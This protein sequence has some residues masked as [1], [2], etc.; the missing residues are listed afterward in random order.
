MGDDLPVESVRVGSIH[1]YSPLVFLV[2]ALCYH[3]L[4]VYR[5]EKL[6]K[7]CS[8]LCLLLILAIIRQEVRVVVLH[9][10]CQL[11]Q[12]RNLLLRDAEPVLG[13]VDSDG[14]ERTEPLNNFV[15]RSILSLEVC[16]L[17]H[18]VTN[19]SKSIIF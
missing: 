1:K 17:H 7:N 11:L 10:R 13:E 5:S 9:L 12:L 15:S 2:E 19:S 4:S 14:C 6:T 18:I 16:H 3:R 8:R